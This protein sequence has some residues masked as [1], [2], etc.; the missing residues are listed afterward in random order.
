MTLQRNNMILSDDGKKFVGLKNPDDTEFLFSKPAP[1]QIATTALLCGDSHTD[2]HQYI[3]GT[4]GNEQL[5]TGTHTFAS[6][7]AGADVTYYKFAQ[8]G[9]NS[10]DWITGYLTSAVAAVVPGVTVA[11]VRLG[12]MTL[13]VVFRLLLQSKTWLLYTVRYQRLAPTLLLSLYLLACR[14]LLL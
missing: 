9:I 13:V 6:G 2:T 10:I 3:V 1:N 7:L 8:N 12:T 11:F 4:Y 14:G 5:E